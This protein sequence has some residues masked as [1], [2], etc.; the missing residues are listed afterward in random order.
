VRVTEKDNHLKGSYATMD[1]KTGRTTVL[2]H[3]PLDP[4]KSPTSQ[5]QNQVRV[6]LGGGK[7]L[8]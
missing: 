8:K 7:P 6:L 3:D 1:R 4:K 5:T 2:N